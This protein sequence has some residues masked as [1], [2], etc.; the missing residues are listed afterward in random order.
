MSEIVCFLLTETTKVERRLRRFCW[1]GRGEACRI[2]RLGYHNANVTVG[3]LEKPRDGEE[4]AP[5]VS[6]IVPHADPIW[7]IAC[8]ACGYQF[9]D[10]DQWQV[11]DYRLYENVERGVLTI[12][13]E[14]PP[15]AMWW[16][17]WRAGFGSI[18]WEER[19]QGPHLVVM[20]PAGEWDL[21]MKSDN[22]L[23]WKWEGEPPDVSAHPSIG[24][25]KPYRYH[26]WLR[27]G[28]LYDA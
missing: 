7:P 11:N 17:F 18:Y 1:T 12:L 24:I 4:E 8:E 22:G 14:A 20:T 28:T 10:T 6:E 2:G 3:R 13:D 26:G 9:Q 23:G 19:G 5:T 21:D 27:N 16:A 25:G 15:G